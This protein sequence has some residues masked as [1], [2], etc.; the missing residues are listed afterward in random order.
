MSS[1]GAVA[2]L[3]AAG[4]LIGG[5][6]GFIGGEA[7]A[8]AYKKAA[9]FSH[10]NAIISQEAGDI[11]L[12]QTGRAIFKTIGAQKAGYAGAGLTGG[13]SAQEV[14]RSSVSQGSLEKAIVNEQTQINVIGYLSQE[15]QFKGM[16]AAAD[17]AAKGGLLSGILSAA[18][19]IAPFVLSDR[20]IKTDIEQIGSHGPLGI[21]RFR[22]I[23][24]DEQHVGVMT[25]EVAIH[26]PH[27]LGPI[28]DG[29]ATV[30]YRALGLS[31]LLEMG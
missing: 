21:Y 22:F 27:A 1:A 10:Q 26:A 12:E 31:H 28:V 20:R 8:D 25:D 18:A 9:K 5:L 7:E 17:A 2:G 4:D 19:T 24:D 13:G 30:D 11:K 6:F 16:A 14:L 23:N 29:Y 15:A 3:G